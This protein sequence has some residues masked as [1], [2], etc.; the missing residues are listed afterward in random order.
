LKALRY[1]LPMLC[2]F[3]GMNSLGGNNARAAS[4]R[5]GTDPN[6]IIFSRSHQPVS[7][8]TEAGGVLQIGITA[9][10]PIREVLING[11][12]VPGTAG[13]SVAEIEFPY[14]LQPGENRFAVIV[15]TDEGKSEKA[16]VVHLVESLDAGKDPF[17]LIGIA[18]VTSLDNVTSAKDDKQ[19]GSK[20]SLV[21]VPRYEMPLGDAAL[22]FQ[23]I[24]LRERF[25]KRD[26]SGNEISYTQVLVQWLKDKTELGDISV[27][28]AMNDIRTNNDNPLLGE[29][30]S[31]TESVIMATLQQEISQDLSWKARGDFTIRDSKEEVTS[32]NDEADAREFGLEGGLD[33]KAMGI[34][35]DAK[36]GYSI[37]DAKGDYVDS[38]T[39]KLDVRLKYPV[40]DFVPGLG[41]AYREKSFKNRNA[42]NV[43]QKDKTTTALAKVDY[44]WG[45][46]PDSLLTLKLQTKT[47]TSNVSTSEYSA[48]EINLALTV[49]F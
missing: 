38:S 39:A 1:L 27:G 22:R 34:S 19:S 5:E 14:Q 25:S 16:F 17:Q 24:L 21:V 45:L 18:G 6:I 35:G 42:S 10:S 30:Q 31:M 20:L 46:L 41:F 37:N 13:D 48:T 4:T 36:A 2:L 44:K 3:C 28:V 9:F 26:F 12:P 49:V 32:A 23:A 47:Q 15:T 33:V 43:K 11:A 7:R 29:D 8:Q 40:G